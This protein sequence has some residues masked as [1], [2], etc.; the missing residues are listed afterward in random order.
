[1]QHK[2]TYFLKKFDSLEGALEEEGERRIRRRRR[3]R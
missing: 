2:K 1:M 3:K